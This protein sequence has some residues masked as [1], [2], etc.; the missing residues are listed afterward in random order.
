MFFLMRTACCRVFLYP[1]FR[2]T[3]RADCPLMKENLILERENCILISNSK[4][5]I[6]QAAKDQLRGVANLPGVERAV[7]LP[8]L[9]P[10]KTPVG[11][12]VLSR[13]RFY[14]HLIGNDIGCGMTLFATN[15]KMKKFRMEKWVTRLNSI[16]ELG[17]IPAENP[18][19][20]E[21]PIRDLGTIG[22]GNHFA[23]FQCVD[24][25]FDEK[26]AEELG[27]SK[28]RLLLLIHSGSRGYG[29]EILNRFYDPAGLEDGSKRAADYLEEHGNA[30]LWASRNRIVTA[31]KLLRYL[32]VDE[33]AAVLIDKC[34]N[35]V[36]R[37]DEGWLH[38][39]GSVSTR[40]GAVV[41][42]GSR[43][44]MTYVC[45]PEADTA[46]S[47]DSVSHGAGRKWARSIC[48]SRIDRRYDRDSIRSTG[49]KSRVVCHDTNLLF[50][51]APEA[52]KSVEQVVDSLKEA[53]LVTTAAALKPLITFKG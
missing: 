48:R 2:E 5:W 53:K 43:G 17:D 15:V 50:A 3:M 44:S 35:Y 41:I 38:R 8:D 51:E 27:L 6:E 11:M 9:H 37:T 7:G 29:Q 25:I 49:L 21:C 19:G 22:L 12:A 42:P 32:G 28:D 46:L 34:H 45:I 30:L 33:D 13:G 16:R 18:Y 52:Y 4:N 14:P 20:E 36:E 1:F 24:S 39:K 23:E 47:L 31:R 10:G 26:A 40:H